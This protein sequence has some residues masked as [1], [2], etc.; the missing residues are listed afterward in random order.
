MSIT[1]TGKQSTTLPSYVRKS[2]GCETKVIINGVEQGEKAIS[3][4]DDGKEHKVEM[5][6]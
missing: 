4:V 1:G 6:I 5:R 3:L 2:I